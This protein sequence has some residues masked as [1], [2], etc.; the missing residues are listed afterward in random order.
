ML[1]ETLVI[2]EWPGPE[3][4]TDLRD[5]RAR[6]GPRARQGLRVLQGRRGNWGSQDCPGIQVD[7]GQ[8]AQMGFLDSWELSEKKEKKVLL[9]N[10]AVPVR[11]AGTER[12]EPEEHEGPPGNLEIREGQET[13]DPQALPENG[14][15]KDLRDLME[16]QDPKAPWVPLVKMASP[17][18]QVKEENRDSKAKRDPQDPP[19]WWGPRVNLESRDLQETEGTPGLQGSPESTVCREWP[20]RREER[21]TQVYRGP[22]GRMAPLD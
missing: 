12:E 22:P 15:L 8:R 18:T 1:K 11:G 19:V 17:D 2:T 16:R 9:A 13:M 6:W 4:K 5:P 10:R 7:R 21:G 20:G 14:D 3:E